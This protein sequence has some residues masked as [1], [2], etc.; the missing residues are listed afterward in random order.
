AQATIAVAHGDTLYGIARQRTNG[1]RGSINQMMLALKAANP[2]AFFK[3]NIDNLKA[4]AILRIPTRDEID[5]ISIAEANAEVHRQYEAWR[6]AK[7]HP[8]TVLAGSAARAAARSAPQPG[9]AAPASDHLSLTP[10]TGKSSGAN[11]R[12]GVAGGTGSETVAGLRQQLQND[13]GSLISLNQSNADLVS[14]VQSLKAISGKSDKLLSFKDATVAE[15]QRKLAQVQAGKPGA[16]TGAS[17]ATAASGSTAAAT[18]PANSAVAA[19]QPAASASNAA[20]PAVAKKPS[21]KPAAQ[22]SRNIAQPWYERPIAWIIAGL[23]VLAL[24]LVAL[25]T[26][27]RRPSAPAPARGPLPD[28]DDVSGTSDA[29]P[30]QPE[31]A[32]DEEALYA[33][34]AEH[35]GDLEAHLQ[36]CRLFYTRSDANR[37]VE[38]A[39]AMH[40]EVADPECAE[41]CEV[42][43]MGEVLTPHHPLFAEHI[44]AA[45]PEDPYGLTALRQPT[46]SD[47]DAT[48][49][50]A[51]AVGDPVAPAEEPHETIPPSAGIPEAPPA[52]PTPSADEPAFSDDPVDTKLDLARAYLD[53]GDP[54]G[55]RAMLEEVIEEGSQTQKD[56]AK[57][58]LVEAGS[59]D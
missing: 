16:A 43:V 21:A 2:E 33:R 13:R 7:P 9:K 5:K 23:V 51:P 41:W 50:R 35:P 39:E 30:Q 32:G 58:L 12:A 22:S 3:N 14:R 24:I 59:P 11:N 56:E 49:V 36:L 45:A 57:R 40:E 31:P 38:A 17:T 1:T 28:P 27:K 52:I 47:D 42:L 15:L 44:D 54:V 18:A 26:R 34:L 46:D 29:T 20:H 19:T 10:P 8:A 53:M 48:I 25:F 6:A 4:G 37:F 55:A